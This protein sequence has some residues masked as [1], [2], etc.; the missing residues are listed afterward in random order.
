MGFVNCRGWR[1]RE[2]DLKIATGLKRLEVSG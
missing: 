2:E 1:S